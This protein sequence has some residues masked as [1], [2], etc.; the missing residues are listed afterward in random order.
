MLS[1]YAQIKYVKSVWGVVKG[2]IEK[3]IWCGLEDFYKALLNALQSEY[4]IPPAKS[5]SRRSKR[6]ETDSPIYPSYILLINHFANS[7]TAFTQK[8]A[9]DD[10]PVKVKFGPTVTTH[11]IPSDSAPPIATAKLT[12]QMKKSTSLPSV[13]LAETKLRSNIFM[14]HFSIFVVVLIIALVLLNIYLMTKLYSLTTSP[15]LSAAGGI[16]HN[17]IPIIR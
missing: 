15:S 12:S 3:N 4:C 2:F 5:K 10:A 7:H 13:K 9:V 14:E 8:S 16:Q 11:V 6:G 1:V 17:E